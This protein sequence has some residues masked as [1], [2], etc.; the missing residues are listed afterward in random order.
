M[1]KNRNKITRL[2]RFVSLLLLCV[3]LLSSGLMQI[4]ASAQESSRKTVRVGWYE[5]AYCCRDR[6]GR[7]SGIAYEYQQKIAAHTGW[8]Y[9][10]VED[11][12]PNLLTMLMNGEI[13]LLSDVSRTEER[14]EFML[15]PSL[16]MGTEAYYIYI[17]ADNDAVN[18][19]DVRT[20][21][22]KKVGVNKGS[23]QENMLIEWAQSN[24]I[25]IN[26]VEMTV[27]EA[28]SMNLLQRREIDAFVSLDN[29]GAKERVLPVCKIG[30]SE[31]YFAVNK[32]RPDLLNELSAALSSI[33]DED[34]YFNQRMFD[35][36]VQL[37]KTNAF[38]SLNQE[39]WLSKHGAIRIGFRDDYLPFCA[40][41][42]NTGEVTGAL[43]NFIA[44]ASNCLKN[45]EIH[46]DAIPFS[47][48]NAALD[49]MKNG[50]IDCVF[51]VNL[52]SDYCEKS[53]IITINPIMQTE[54]NVMVRAADRP[55][56]AP[57][58]ELKVAVN[59]GN[60]DYETFIMDCIPDWKIVFC[61]DVNDC[62]QAVA[63]K[64]ADCLLICDYRTNGVNS[65][66]DQYKLA[67]LPSGEAMKLSVAVRKGD[68]VL[69][70]IL[71][72]ISNLTS[73]ETMEYAL[74][75]YIYTN[76]NFSIKDFLKDNWIAVVAALTVIFAIIIFLLVLR[77]K[78]ERK[79]N[80]QQKQ[81]DENLR[82][83][84]EQK[85]KLQSITKIAY[86]D[87]LTGVKSKHA[88][89]EAEDKLDR[90]IADDTLK[91]FAMVL[92]DMNGL[93]EIN[94]TKG[95]DVGD[96]YIKELCGIIC[97]HFKHSPVYRVGGDEFVAVLE[98][99]DYM[100]REELL[101]VF[102]KKMDNNLAEGR[103]T[104]ASGYAVFDPTTDKSS[105][106]VLERADENMYRRKRSMKESIQ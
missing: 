23:V 56:I 25:A 16:A 45:A 39:S 10:Y 7:R 100:N 4:T 75:S 80:E 12:W 99:E 96:R 85:E 102:E 18:S 93:K 3:F 98:G 1:S 15:F 6:F 2:N 33:Q 9:E 88:F 91:E 32:N 11:S 72:K 104:I 30:S 29:F 66:R 60:I 34:P 54:M 38:L 14:K 35:Q 44:H 5:S 17:D 20:L 69:Y 48:T 78:S 83:E 103:A 95:H 73:N 28:E 90:R 47:S 82:R 62:F 13:D 26:I 67:V 50:E 37:T 41:D 63:S 31:Y 76:Q 46:F 27:D 101:A 92:F 79:L 59:E 22:G 106:S 21:S 84:L 24:D 58:K 68:H 53:G 43:K 40:L 81:I 70:S 105:H 61:A 42:K 87:D 65:L 77:L 97:S 8:T 49:A 51:P 19:E 57:G 52:S 74:L 71:N 55:E 64:K 86:T 36:Y 89:V 94:D